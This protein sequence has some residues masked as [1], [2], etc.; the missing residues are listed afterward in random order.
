[1]EKIQHKMIPVNGL[2]MHVAEIREGPLVLFLH[3]FPELWY[4]WCHQMVFMATC[5]YRAVALDMRGYGDTIG[6]P[7]D[8][9]LNFYVLHLVGDM[10][11]LLDVVAPNADKVFVVGHDWGALVAWHLCLYMPDR[12]KALVSLSLAYMPRDPEMNIVEMGRK[13]YVYDIFVCRFLVRILS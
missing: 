1:M 5:G 9:P 8:D 12:V 6:V 3:G 13:V 4:S 2:N 10:I 11:Y 7:I